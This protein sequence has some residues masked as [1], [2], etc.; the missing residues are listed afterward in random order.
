[1]QL[2]VGINKASELFN[3][4]SF[5]FSTLSCIN[6]FIG[7]YE[8]ELTNVLTGLFWFAN[9]SKTNFSSFSLV[10]SIVNWFRRLFFI[11]L[12][13]VD[14]VLLIQVTFAPFSRKPSIIAD[15]ILPL[16]PVTKQCTYLRSITYGYD[17]II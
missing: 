15:P 10:A 1:M 11:L 16:P 13:I 14:L 7:L 2:L 3:I 5:Y 8:Q 12:K 6:F 9:S 4:E 17:N